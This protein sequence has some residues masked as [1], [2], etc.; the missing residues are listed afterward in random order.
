MSKPK[1]AIVLLSYNS[2]EL[3][4]KYLP[5]IK[6]SIPAEKDYQVIV[7][8]NASSDAIGE[9]V[10]SEHSDV[11]LITLKENHGF[12]N[13]YVESLAQIDAKYYCLISSDIEVT[14]GFTEPAIDLLESD[15]TI[16]ACQPKIMSWD[17]RKEFEYAGA[18]GGYIDHLGYPFLQGSNGKRGGRRPRTIRYRSRIF[19]ASGACLLLE[20]TCTMRQVDLIMIF[21]RIWRKLIFA[22]A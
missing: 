13:G 16:A 2:L 17:R 4:V 10:K 7:V 5:L 22:G 15:E 18:A 12:T 14:A 9:Y 6:D 20:R 8:D 1:L 3:V 19:W 21:L 11:R